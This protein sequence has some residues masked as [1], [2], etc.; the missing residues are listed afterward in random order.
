MRGL[1]TSLRDRKRYIAF[2]IICEKEVDGQMFAKALEDKVVEL[3]GEIA[4]ADCKISLEYFSN[5]KGIIKCKRENV[6]KVLMA[7][8]LLTEI[9]GFKVLPITVGTSGTIRKCKKYL[10]VS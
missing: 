4:L 9:D 6:D 8:T 7:L 3:F 10:E 5:C 1:P 2:K